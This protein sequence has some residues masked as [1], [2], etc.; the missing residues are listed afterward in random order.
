MD[1]F[2]SVTKLN[3]V[4]NFFQGVIPIAD[5]IEFDQ[6][7]KDLYIRIVKAK[8]STTDKLFSI[9]FVAQWIVGIFFAT[10]VQIYLAVVVGAVIAAIPIYFIVKNPG[11]KNNQYLVAASQMFFSI[12]LSH[13][14]GGQIETHIHAIGSLAVLSA[15]R[16]FR[17]LLLATLIT[18]ADHVVRGA[19]HYISWI[20]I[21]NAFL[22]FA[23][24]GS[25]AELRGLVFA[26][27]ISEQLKNIA[28]ENYKALLATISQSMI[29]TQTDQWGNIEY[30]NDQ[31]SEI[32]GYKP[33]E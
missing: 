1:N 20:V 5:K 31:F 17:P 19:F 15:Y 30:V 24:V 21:E 10:D 25:I 4:K 13:V 12:L 9:M 28:T 6:A 16:D 27:S 8:D 2:E 32:S 7:Q 23:I 3:L 22:F 29:V 18:A 11:S 26:Q 14:T 33:E